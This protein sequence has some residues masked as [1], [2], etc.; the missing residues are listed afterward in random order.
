MA[1]EGQRAIPPRSSA[2]VGAF[3]GRG[4][5]TKDEEFD[6]DEE[7]QGESELAEEEAPCEG[8]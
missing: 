5:F 6:E 7:Y 2:K 8:A 4:S 1:R 3:V